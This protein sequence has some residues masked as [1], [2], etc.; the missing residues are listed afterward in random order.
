M[1]VLFYGES[2]V[3]GTGLAQVT[4]TIVDALQE[5]GHNIE[6]VGMNH[7]GVAS[8]DKEKY[9]Y[10]IVTPLDECPHAFP[11]IRERII[12]GN[13]DVLIVSTD[14]GRDLPVYE[15]L[16]EIEKKPFVVGYYAV[17]CDVINPETF[18][19]LEWCN[20]KIAYTEHG[21]NTIEHYRPDMKGLINVINLAC[22]PDV[23]YPLSETERLA[24]RKE[25]FYL[26]ED[27][28]TFMVVNVNRNQPRKD[29]GRTLEIFHRF[30]LS[31]PNSK[32]YMHGQQNDIGGNLPLMASMVGMEIGKEVLFT[33]ESYNVFQGFTREYLN[34]IYNAA[35]CLVSTSLGEGW[36]LSTTE[37]MAATT[38]VVVPNNTSFTEIVGY[39]QERGYLVRSGG[40]IDH[41]LWL[42]GLTNHPHSVVHSDDMLDTLDIVYQN[43][44]YAKIKACHAR[45]WCLERTPIIIGE[46]WKAL[47]KKL[48]EGLTEK[49][50][51]NV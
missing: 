21:K 2:P 37:A 13:Y 33:H 9:P 27:D 31:H 20:V 42:Y 48:E 43:P 46:R 8:F 24:A 14:F 19:T 47:F 18:N 15:A 26:E 35:D 50:K 11:T 10:N 17:D 32:L 4:R 45:A 23:F 36:G 34:K 3:V 12:N 25:L 30:Y 22:E 41:S 7:H 29:L 16:A 51:V 38:P 39:S 28:D 40:D 44:D 6:I 5:D 49:E 1:R